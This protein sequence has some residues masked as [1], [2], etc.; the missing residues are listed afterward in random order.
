MRWG[1]RMG[2]GMGGKWR[3]RWWTG[4]GI[5]DWRWEIGTVPRR[6]LLALNLALSSIR[7]PFALRSKD[8]SNHN[9]LPTTSVCVVL[10]P[11]Q[12]PD[13]PHLSEGLGSGLSKSSSPKSIP[14]VHHNTHRKVT[15]C[16]SLPSVSIPSPPHHQTYHCIIPHIPLQPCSV[17]LD[18]IPSPPSPLPPQPACLAS[19]PT[20]A[21]CLRPLA[22][23]RCK[24]APG[25]GMQVARKRCFRN[26]HDT[27]NAGSLNG[28]R[29]AGMGGVGGMHQPA[30][31]GDVWLRGCSSGLG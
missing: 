18:N 17:T 12:S 6:V 7:R 8:C 10:A 5:G 24:H 20:D 31:V 22:A 2:M 19:R 13:F 30:R 14:P 11:R 28:S 4:W 16:P 26:E 15:P 25:C 3:S 1:W 27:T 29:Q 23:V 9:L 21:C